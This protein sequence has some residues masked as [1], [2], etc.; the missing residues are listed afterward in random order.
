MFRFILII[1]YL[2]VVAIFSITAEARNENLMVV[3]EHMPPFQFI[4]ENPKYPVKG[5]SIDVLKSTLQQAVI[6]YSIMPMSW[7]RAYR[8]GQKKPNTLILSMVRKPEREQE[9][10]WLIKLSDSK[11]SLWSNKNNKSKLTSLDQI[12]NE[13]IAISRH[14]HHQFILKNYPNI[15]DKNIIL[16]N[17]KEQ[18]IA[19]IIKNRA[20]YFFAN[21]Y[22]LNWRLKLMSI[23]K[24][25]ITE[26]F[27]L[28]NSVDE[29]YIAASKNTS[30][31]IRQKITTAYQELQAQGKIKAIADKWF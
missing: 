15:T 31:R 17:S 9:F 7:S 20:Q 3:T 10:H 18:A 12:S 25:D 19:L 16:T 6:D 28:S 21:E 13:I 29:L 5:Y 14:D 11:T 30:L 24:N 8:I 2:L 26:V 1:I 4:D 27:E 23:A 22:I